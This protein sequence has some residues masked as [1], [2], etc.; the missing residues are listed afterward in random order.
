MYPAS[1]AREPRKL[2][3]METAAVYHKGDFIGLY[4]VHFKNWRKL[5]LIKSIA[6]GITVTFKVMVDGVDP[7]D[8]YILEVD[9]LLGLRYLPGFSPTDNAARLLPR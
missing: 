7:Y 9:D 8:H 5:A 3:E 1:H 2:R 4:N 6:N